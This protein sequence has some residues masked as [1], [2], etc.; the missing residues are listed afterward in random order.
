MHFCNLY[1]SILLTFNIVP[2]NIFLIV[3][4]VGC[5]V[6]AFFV[7]LPLAPFPISEGAGLIVGAGFTVGAT[8]GLFDGELVGSSVGEGV[9]VVSSV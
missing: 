3:L 9:G 2:D 6:Y 4:C 1:T 5:R 7:L 8:V